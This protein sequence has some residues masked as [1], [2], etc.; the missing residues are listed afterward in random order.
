MSRLKYSVLGFCLLSVLLIP[1]AVAVKSGDEIVWDNR[2]KSEHFGKRSIEES[3]KVIKLS[4]P[5]RAEDP[6]LVPIKITSRFAQSKDRYIKSIT[7]FID[8]NPVPYSAEFHFTPESGRADLAMRVRVNTYT[9][10]RAVAETN[11][12]KL[13]MNKVFVKATGG[14]SAP[15]GADLEEAMKRLGKMKFRIDGDPQT[16]TPTLAQLLISHPN[17]TGLQ[18]DQVSRIYKPSHY[19]EEMNISFNG[20]PVLRAKT[21]IAISADPNFRFYFVPRENGILKAD[22]KDNTG[23]SFSGTFDIEL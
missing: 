9:Y 15:I 3:D 8:N 23:L 1:F 22:I 18:M 17:V 7:L 11:D 4:A 5:I 6:A 2:L 10:V 12:G 19:I 20:K 21:D 13:S 16:N 14:C